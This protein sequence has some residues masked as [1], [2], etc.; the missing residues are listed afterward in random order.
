MFGWF[1]AS[2]P[3]DVRAKSW[4]EERL[5]WLNRE[6]EASVFSDDK[7]IVLPL[8][9][10]FPDPY[11]GSEESVW[12]M[13]QRI[14]GYMDVAPSL[15]DLQFCSDAGN[16][17]L[18]NDLGQYLPHS[19]GTY[20][21]GEEKFVV[22][23][24]RNGLDRPMELVGT[25]A[26][27]LAHVRLLGESRISRD[28]YDNEL[29]TDLTVI[30]FGLGI[31]LANVPR[32]WESGYGKWP[33]SDLKKPEYMTPPMFGYALAHLAWFRNEKKPDWARHLHPNARAN[34]KQGIHFLEKTRDSVYQPWHVRLEIS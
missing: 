23:V 16:L 26:H 6:F 11:D 20:S 7:P 1:S 3:V 33:E 8:Q 18:V 28:A 30:F 31:F 14:C 5:L 4:I 25:L 34:L 22:R 13:F 29:L 2:C 10:Y 21:E 17:W 24:D 12:N 32:N 15:I 19:A 27:E 9:E